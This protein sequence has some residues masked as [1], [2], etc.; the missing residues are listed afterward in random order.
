LQH[1][2]HIE[3]GA[4]TEDP[5]PFALVIFDG[6]FHSGQD[7]RANPAT[8]N[9]LNSGKTLVILNNT[10]DHRSHLAG[11]LWAHSSGS[12]P[13]VAFVV[14]RRSASTSPRLIQVDFPLSSGKHPKTDAE[15]WIDLI[16]RSAS[17]TN[18]SPAMTGD[19]QTVVSFDELTPATL[20]ISARVNSL[21]APPGFSLSYPSPRVSTTSQVTFETLIYAML[22]GN[23]PTSYQHK[24]FARQYLLASPDLIFNSNEATEIYTTYHSHLSPPVS[25]AL[26]FNDQ[27][28]LSVQVP[29]EIQDLVGVVENLPEAANNVTQLTTSQSQSESV[30]LSASA[31][32]SG[33]SIVGSIGVSWSESWTWEQEQTVDISDWSAE[34]QVSADTA[35]YIFSAPGVPLIPPLLST[36]GTIPVFA[37][38]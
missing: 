19:G 37:R 10:D 38:G 4:G 32:F 31:G 17:G 26:G 16:Q 12:S 28:T 11:L 24:I 3:Q 2:Y 34:S 1:R 35:S 15:N 36:S 8:A 18:I 7:I 13:G 6:N 29:S 23:S 33:Q 22:E 20:T 9:F 14:R 5:T 21:G 25:S 30:G 27:T